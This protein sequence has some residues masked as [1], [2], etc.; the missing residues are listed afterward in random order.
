MAINT[1][2]M[3][4][5]LSFCELATANDETSWIRAQDNT[6]QEASISVDQA[7]V[8]FYSYEDGGNYKC[9]RSVIA[10]DVNSVKGLDRNPTLRIAGVT[11]ASAVTA[12]ECSYMADISSLSSEADA[13]TLW[14]TIKSGS[15][16]SVAAENFVSLTAWT[17]ITLNDAARREIVDNAVFTV[18]LV[19]YDNDHLGVAPTGTLDSRTS[20]Y[21]T[22]G[23]SAFA[24]DAELSGSWYQGFQRA[25]GSYLTGDFVF[26]NN[27][28]QN[29]SDQYV[30]QADQVP[31]TMGT[32]TVKNIRGLRDGD[33][34][35]YKVT[36]E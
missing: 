31:F 23:G 22:S 14:A 19:T 30:R 29:C 4:N 25:E 35:T 34:K 12:I 13:N 15:L 24:P 36:R 33:D 7:S 9:V 20:Y 32:R 21:G 2:Q 6:S 3:V 17:E 8:T 28:L 10:F 5:A 11:A 16:R 27:T 1:D 18:A 26:R